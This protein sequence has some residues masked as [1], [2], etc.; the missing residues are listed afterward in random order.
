MKRRELGCSLAAVAALAALAMPA[1]AADPYPSRAIKV[2]VPYA[3]GGVVDVQT[4][5]VTQI[6][7]KLLKQPMVVEPKPG[8]S[9]NIGADAVARAEPDGYT[10][11][12]SAS[13]LNTAPMMEKNLSWRIEQFTPVGRFSLSPSYFAV[14]ANSPARTV[15]EFAE[16]ARK[17]PMPLQYANGGNGTPQQIANELFATEAGIKLES[18]MYKGAPPSVPDLINGMTAMAVL[19]SSVAYPHAKAG[20]LRVLA[21]MSGNRSAQ[22]PDVPTIAEAGYPGATVLSWYGLHAPA[23]TPPEV[24]RTLANA[25]QQACATAEVKQRLISAGGEEAFLGTRD[26]AAFLDADAKSWAKVLKALPK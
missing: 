22:L 11:L 4:R 19:P 25:M 23:G 5:A 3:P 24:I 26:F 13:F 6:M 17:A 10:L 2:I 21:N 20:T 1:V 9:G 15:K 14:P 12:V 8:A 18:V 7:E 16:M